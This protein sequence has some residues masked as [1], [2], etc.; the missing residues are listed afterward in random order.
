M[1]LWGLV[2]DD[3]AHARV[4]RRPCCAAVVRAEHADRRDAAPQPLRPVR[5][6][7]DRVCAHAAGSG[8]PTA[9][10]LVLVQALDRL[11]AGAAVFALEQ[12]RLVD[13]GEDPAVP[14][15]DGPGPASACAR[16]PSGR[17]AR[18]RS[19]SSPA[20]SRCG[21]SP[22][23]THRS[24]SG[25]ERPVRRLVHGGDLPS[26]EQRTFDVPALPGLVGGEDECT[27]RGAHDDA[28]PHALPLRGRAPAAYRSP[29]GP[30]RLTHSAKNL[31][32]R[33]GAAGTAAD[34]PAPP[35]SARRCRR[36]AR[37]RRG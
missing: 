14:R 20:G 12:P 36:C 5:I 1:S 18:S 28:I 6:D 11:P 34:S 17:P 21:A 26:L 23:R 2:L 7:E 24:P 30:V 35:R 22:A 3:D 13:S 32:D 31:E 33:R 15:S 37:P 8:E 4:L 19:G 16:R 9:A 27:L 10:R 29:R 25:E